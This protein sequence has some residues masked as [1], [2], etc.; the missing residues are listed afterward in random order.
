MAS[1]VQQPVAPGAALELQQ[2]APALVKHELASDVLAAQARA[3]VQARYIVAATPGNQRDW[4]TV[5][6]RILHD[7]ER[8]TFAE[9]AIYK[10][11][12]GNSTVTGLSIRFA[13]SAKRA[14]GNLLTER[15]VIYDDPQKRIVRITVTDLESNATD[16]K[17][18]TLEKTVERRSPKGRNIVSQRINSYGD[19][20]Y[21]VEATE[22]ELLT[23]ESSL[24]SK[25][26]RQLTLK[27][28]PGDIQDEALRAIRCTQE[29]AD[30]TDPDAAKKRLMDA[31]DDI[32][33]RVPDLKSFLGIDSLDSMQPSDL[34]QLREIFTAIREGETNWR[35]VME[36]REA[37]RGKKS[38]GEASA[39][40][41][42]LTEKVRQKAAKASAPVAE[43]NPEEKSV[44]EAWR[45]LGWTEEKG[46]ADRHQFKGKL[47]EYQEY[48][49][50]L[51]DQMN[52]T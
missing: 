8:P 36:Q 30:K 9:T 52:A 14:M 26:E 29:K 3:Q 15:T 18:V 10:K 2:Q 33:I 5:R 25:I 47:S 1:T 24:L 48:L 21:I 50:N 6:Q 27:M 19:A 7:C 35:E 43:A 23:K 32:G 17:E 16:Q 45:I 37:A 4:D 46:T 40:T 38:E 20:V 44:A 28:L 12:V 39:K 13:E 11:P 34:K 51:I 42:S 22:D 49:G 41:Q 31:F